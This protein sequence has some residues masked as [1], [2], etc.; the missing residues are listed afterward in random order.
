MQNLIEDLPMFAILG[1]SNGFPVNHLE[2]QFADQES[3]TTSDICPFF[4]DISGTG[5][6]G[7]IFAMALR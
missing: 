6:L 2:G 5:R 7:K 4:P 1:L 3:V